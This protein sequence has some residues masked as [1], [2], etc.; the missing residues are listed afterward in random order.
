MCAISA[1]IVERGGS[2]DAGRIVKETAA[3]VGGGGGGRKDFASAGG[4][5]A[6]KLDEALAAVAGIVTG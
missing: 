2:F 3:I 4:R 5:D 1:D 6:S